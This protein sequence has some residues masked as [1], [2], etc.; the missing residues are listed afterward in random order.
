VTRLRGAAIL[1]LSALAGASAIRCA[2]HP[3]DAVVLRGGADGGGPGLD[4]TED[5]GA[6][7][8]WPN[9][10]SQANSD[11]WIATHHDQIAQ[12][13]PRVLVLDFANRFQPESG[14]VV[15]AGY[16]LDQTV[17][18]L[19]QRHFDAFAVG[20]R[21]RG[22]GN[23]AAPAFLKYQ[24]YRIVDLRD[25]SGQVNSNKLPTSN[26]GS[27]DYAQLNT[28]AFAD[29]MGVADPDHP[30]AN[31]TLCQL[32]EKGVI[33]E[34]WGMA[35][36]PITASDPVSIKFA[37]YTET[38]QAYDVHDQRIPGQLVCTTSPCIDQTLPCSVTTRL[39]DFNPGRG[40]GCH[41]FVTGLVWEGYLVGG[42]LPAF[43]RVARTFF[44]FDFDQRFGAPFS[45]FYNAC[46]PAPADAGPC[47]RWPS[48]TRA[49]SGP[50]SANTFD[51]SPMSAGC[52]NVGF[53]PNATGAAQQD[54]ALTVMTSC[55]N[56]GLRNGGDGGDLATPY[57][58]SLPVSD[59]ANAAGVASGDCAGPQVT[60]MFASMPGLGTTATAP[61]GTPMKNWWPYLFY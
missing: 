6:I 54:D 38:K 26:N 16:P 11:P 31:L 18:P 41:M 21:Y 17:T 13:Q 61:D 1:G 35:A 20:S 36:D 29:M 42:V 25:D 55:E 46:P 2:A 47:I 39:Y 52:G 58:T 60:Y 34:V 49:V 19:V 24:I 30:G 15:A 33:N 5:G 50:A 59:Y 12:M 56:Y 9:T 57:T 45:S 48:S 53:P 51:F 7:L 37:E 4:S 14:A 8:I 3:L 40:A 10:V 28:T 27:V 43:S 22:Y 23:Q 44:N 32:F